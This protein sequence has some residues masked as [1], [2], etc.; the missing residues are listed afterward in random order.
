M[1]D[2]MIREALERLRIRKEKDLHNGLVDRTRREPAE[3]NWDLAESVF[4]PEELAE[5]SLPVRRLGFYLKLDF[6][7]F[8]L[9]ILFLTLLPTD[10]VFGDPYSGFEALL[11]G[12]LFVSFFG[13]WVLLSLRRSRR[14]NFTREF[15]LRLEARKKAGR[16]TV[17]AEEETP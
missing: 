10:T 16:N 8:W 11:I 3:K 4:T 7:A 9:S 5:A 1:N 2:D 12:L 15:A 17:T 14:Q 6:A 13:W